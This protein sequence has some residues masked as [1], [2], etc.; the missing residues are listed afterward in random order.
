MTKHIYIRACHDI[1]RDS[2]GEA[3]HFLQAIR[4]IQETFNFTKECKVGER[5]KR[6]DQAS[7]QTPLLTEV[8][9]RWQAQ[10]PRH[11]ARCS[12]GRSRRVFPTPVLPASR[13]PPLSLKPRNPEQ[14]HPAFTQ[15]ITDHAESRM[16]NTHEPHSSNQHPRPARMVHPVLWSSC[17]DFQAVTPFSS[18]TAVLQQYPTC[19]CFL[20]ECHKTIYAGTQHDGLSRFR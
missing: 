3:Q 17:T 13:T 10:L 2:L 14:T 7:N 5:T 20:Q 12:L 8:H 4:K 1:L 16:T 15:A 19:T 6:D 9:S 11:S 18:G